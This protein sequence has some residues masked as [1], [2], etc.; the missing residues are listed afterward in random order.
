MRFHKL[1]LGLAGAIIAAV[2][3]APASLGSLQVP[4]DTMKATGVCGEYQLSGENERFPILANNHYENIPEGYLML[5]FFNINC[6]FCVVWY[7]RDAIGD[8]MY[9]GGRGYAPP[10]RVK[11]S[12]SY[13]CF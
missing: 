11:G 1:S 13:Y 8:V 3:A 6:D 10:E 5:D 9:S 2:Q 7:G 4:D 12:K